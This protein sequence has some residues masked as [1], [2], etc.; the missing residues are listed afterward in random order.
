MSAWMNGCG[1]GYWVYGCEEVDGLVSGC[2]DGVWVS[3][4][5]VSVT[6]GGLAEWPRDWGCGEWL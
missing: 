4:Y 2:S 1:I 6:L 5:K 3:G